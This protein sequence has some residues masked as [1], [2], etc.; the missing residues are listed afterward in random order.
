MNAKHMRINCGPFPEWGLNEEARAPEDPA[1][2]LVALV[3]CGRLCRQA[4]PCSCLV[5]RCGSVCRQ[6]RPR[7]CCSHKQLGHEW[8]LVADDGVGMTEKTL[9]SGMATLGKQSE[10][11]EEGVQP[12]PA[13]F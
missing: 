6:A 3:L 1:R 12:I 7:F 10:D 4:R 8:L 9:V 5:L 2:C 13:W 11:D